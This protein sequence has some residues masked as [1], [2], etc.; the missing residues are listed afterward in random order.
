[1]THDLSFTVDSPDNHWDLETIY[2]SIVYFYQDPTTDIFEKGFPS[3]KNLMSRALEYFSVIFSD[4]V[5]SL[6]E[7]GAIDTLKG[8]ETLLK[9]NHIWL[10]FM[11][12]YSLQNK[13]KILVQKALILASYKVL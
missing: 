11:K 10:I 9:S 7:D 8:V 4:I 13:S 5:T 6:C 2:S 1:M 12:N 3:G